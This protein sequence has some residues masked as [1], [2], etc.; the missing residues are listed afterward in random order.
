MADTS[1]QSVCR[2][3]MAALADGWCSFPEGLADGCSG[4]GAAQT[5]SSLASWGLGWKQVTLT[6]ICC[7][8]LLPV[9]HLILSCVWF[10][11]VIKDPPPPPPAPKEVWCPHM[12]PLLCFPARC[13]SASLSECCW[14]KD[15]PGGCL[16]WRTGFLK[17]RSLLSQIWMCGSLHRP[18]LSVA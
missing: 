2:L 9:Q 10:F 1:A 15:C 3:G 13:M 4:E 14:R 18:Q 5:A 16:H 6:V 7:L 12:E 8:G 17:S 11:Q